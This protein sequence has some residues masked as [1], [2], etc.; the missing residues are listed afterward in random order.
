MAL[1]ILHQSYGR[2]GGAE[3][4]ALGHYVQL[5]KMNV[6][7]SL[8]YGGLISEGWKRRLSSCGIRE[9]PTGLP[10]RLREMQGIV[11]LLKELSRFDKVIIHHHV[12]PKQAADTVSDCE[13]DPHDAKLSG[14]TDTAIV[15]GELLIG[16]IMMRSVLGL[17]MKPSTALPEPVVLL[18]DIVSGLVDHVTFGV[19]GVAL[20]KITVA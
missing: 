16:R 14:D 6:D 19:V 9:L 2:F 7:V 8:F 20:F 17:H 5:R 18:K 12:D 15:V 11:A 3:R 4:V 10:R 13:M 1:A